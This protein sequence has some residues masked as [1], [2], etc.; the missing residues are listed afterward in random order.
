MLILSVGM[1]G[2]GMVHGKWKL[3]V[4]WVRKRDRQKESA[5]VFI[6]LSPLLVIRIINWHADTDFIVNKM[7]IFEVHWAHRLVGLALLMIVCF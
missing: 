3:K 4:D 6:G 2:D 7:F 5:C 1:V